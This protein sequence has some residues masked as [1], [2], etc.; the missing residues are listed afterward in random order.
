MK[1]TIKLVPRAL[2]EATMQCKKVTAYA[3][4]SSCKVSMLHSLS[5]QVSHYSA[6]IQNTPGWTYVGVYVDEATTGTKDTRTEFQRMLRDCRAGKIDMIL[7]KSVS[8][9]ARNTLTTLQTVRE[10]R[11]LGIDVFFEKES[12][13]SLSVDGEFL[14]TLLAVFAQE[15]SRSV[16]DNLKWRIKEKYKQGKPG[17]ITMY[18]YKLVDGV[19][20]VVPEEAAVIR[21]VAD[22][23]LDGYGGNQ[24]AQMLNDMGHFT[25]TGKEWKAHTIREMLFN[26]K[27]YGDMLLQKKYVVDPIDKKER[28]NRGELPMYHVQGSHEAI[29]DRHTQQRIIEERARRVAMFKPDSAKNRAYPFTSRIVCGKCGANYRRKIA[30]CGT[31]YEKPVWIC[32]TYNELGKSKCASQQ[33]PESI[34]HEMAARVTGAS[35]FDSKLFEDMVQNISVPENGTLIFHMRNGSDITQTWEN[36]SRRHS[37]DAE[38]RQRAREKALEWEANK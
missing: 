5:A 23:Y 21:M 33:I 35:E 3:R 19:L 34:L 36:P 28:L 32:Q 20:Q 14:L 4:V 16:S 2:P 11:A 25:M 1:K 27:I 10:L 24:I 7:T 13:H 30:A 8:R 37:W 17:S 26:E 22:Y 15:E 12:I 38:A 9:F 31:K 6:L 18:G 29:L